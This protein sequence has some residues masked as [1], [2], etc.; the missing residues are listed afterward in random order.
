[1]GLATKTGTWTRSIPNSIRLYFGSIPNHHVVFRHITHPHLPGIFSTMPD[2]MYLNM[3]VFRLGV[4]S[5][6]LV[7]PKIAGNLGD[8]FRFPN[9]WM[10]PHLSFLAPDLLLVYWREN[11]WG[12]WK[13]QWLLLSMIEDF[14]RFRNPQMVY[15]MIMVHLHIISHFFDG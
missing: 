4:P 7:P 2:H 1:M 15:P 12:W 9:F 14:C 3:G 11:D 6:P 8:H 10:S 13:I 5:S